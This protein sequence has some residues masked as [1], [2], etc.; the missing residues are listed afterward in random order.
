[1][2]NNEVIEGL[3]KMVLI[4]NEKYN[5]IKKFPQLTTTAFI[6]KPSAPITLKEIELPL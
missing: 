5:E 4:I 1:M 2:G 3:L 6:C